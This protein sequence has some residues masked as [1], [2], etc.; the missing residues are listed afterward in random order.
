MKTLFIILAVITSILSAI[1]AVL[2]ISNLAVIPAILAFA[3]AFAAHYMSK[4]EGEVRKIIPF[5]FFLTT[6]A[7]MLSLYKAVFIASEVTQ[8]ESLEAKEIQLEEEAIDELEELDLEIEEIEDI[9][10]DE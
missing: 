5:T 10:I 7:L 6:I 8:T 3:F 4:K 9:T 2:P 1:F